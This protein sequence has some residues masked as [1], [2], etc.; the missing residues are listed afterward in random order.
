MGWGVVGGLW[1]HSNYYPTIDMERLH[2]HLHVSLFPRINL[3]RVPFHYIWFP[4]ESNFSTVFPITN[5]FSHQ[6]A[7]ST[8][9]NKLYGYRNPRCL[10]RNLPTKRCEPTTECNFGK[11]SYRHNNRKL[12]PRSPELLDNRNIGWVQ[13][14]E[15]SRILSQE[16]CLLD[17]IVT[18]LD[19]SFSDLSRKANTVLHIVRSVLCDT[20]IKPQICSLCILPRPLTI[21]RIVWQ[22]IDLLDEVASICKSEI[23]QHYWQ[24][25]SSR[26]WKL[27]KKCPFQ[28]KFMLPVLKLQLPPP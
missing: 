20:T 10:T 7:I 3:T 28:N 19:V 21:A 9:A 12:N 26:Q 18:E 2:D 5:R 13:L 15:F 24:K 8:G 16:F 27:L 22:W 14:Q 1:T 4:T 25:T 11:Y 23:S 6:T 17:H